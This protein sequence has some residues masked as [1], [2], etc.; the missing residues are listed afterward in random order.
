[1]CDMCP[2]ILPYK[3]PVYDLAHHESP[4]AQWLELEIKNCQLI[5]RQDFLCSNYE[6]LIIYL[7]RNFHN[8]EI[9]SIDSGAF[10]AF[11]GPSCTL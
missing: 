10:Q 9:V 8:N 6:K 2:A 3:N 11:N 5:V 1:M 7:S 4:I